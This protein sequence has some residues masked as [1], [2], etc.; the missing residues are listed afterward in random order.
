MLTAWV[1]LA[2]D[3]TLV[4]TQR[5]MNGLFAGLWGPIYR[6]GVAV[7]DSDHVH[8]GTVKHALSHRK[9][10]VHVVLLARRNEPLGVD[11]NE[12]AI[13]T[14]DEKVIALANEHAQA[15]E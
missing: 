2:Q 11:V 10:T 14:L 4:L 9:M 13:S 3:G 5:P 15:S 7:P 8:C 6:D 12:V 1:E